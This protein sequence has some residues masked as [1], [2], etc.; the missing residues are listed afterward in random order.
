MPI[1]TATVNCYR[2][3]RYSQVGVDGFPP[4]K[5]TYIGSSMPVCCNRWYNDSNYAF[6]L[7]QDGSFFYHQR[8]FPESQSKKIVDFVRVFYHTFS[9]GEIIFYNTT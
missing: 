5:G 4:L 3:D 6:V 1:I 2:K 9:L 8:K 7:L